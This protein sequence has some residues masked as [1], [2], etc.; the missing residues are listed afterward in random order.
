MNLENFSR[1]VSCH[2]S[3]RNT[4]LI[5]VLLGLKKSSALKN[6]DTDLIWLYRLWCG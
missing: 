6:A 5:G 3:A 2:N 4:I 1:K